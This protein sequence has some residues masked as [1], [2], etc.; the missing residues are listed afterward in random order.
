MQTEKPLKARIVVETETDSLLGQAEKVSILLDGQVLD[1]IRCGKQGVFF[2]D[3][4]SHRLQAKIGN[5][6][7]EILEFRL[8]E[9]D[10]LKFRCYVSGVFKK[11]VALRAQFRRQ[12]VEPR[13]DNSSAARF[14]Q[15]YDDVVP[16]HDELKVSPEASFGD[17]TRAYLALMKDCHPDKVAGL[18]EVEK[19]YAQLRARKISAAYA[20]A[21]K[22][23]G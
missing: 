18:G 1:N 13:V 4:G 15:R 10:V 19:H 14:G 3:L 9:N 12:Y 11:N 20:E 16:W 21:K 7:S 8:Q 23:R 22:L 5:Q 6:E 17:I 2:I